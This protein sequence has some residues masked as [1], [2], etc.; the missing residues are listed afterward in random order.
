MNIQINIYYKKEK[1]EY[2]KYLVENFGSHEMAL[3]VVDELLKVISKGSDEF[4]LKEVRK[5]IVTEISR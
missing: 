1:E 4:D 3:K 2:I 5:M